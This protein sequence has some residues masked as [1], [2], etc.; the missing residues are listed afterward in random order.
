[1]TRCDESLI[2]KIR[3]SSYHKPGSNTRGLD[4]DIV[5]AIIMTT[6]PPIQQIEALKEAVYYVDGKPNFS[7]YADIVNAKLDEAINIIRHHASC[8]I[9]DDGEALKAAH[10][11]FDN[12]FCAGNTTYQAVEEAIVNYKAYAPA[13]INRVTMPVSIEQAITKLMENAEEYSA[14]VNKFRAMRFAQICAKVWG[15]SHE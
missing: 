10:R 13:I 11:A 6:N 7:P 12:C 9:C 8:E 14:P 15:L 3:K 5:E 1:M 2:D 4:L